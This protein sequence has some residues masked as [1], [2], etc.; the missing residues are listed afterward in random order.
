MGKAAWTLIV[1]AMLLAGCERDAPA[2]APDVSG[3]PTVISTEVSGPELSVLAIGDS[4]FAGYGLPDPMQSYPAQL[5]QALRRDGRDVRISNAGVS[6]DTSAAGRQRLAFT[7]D[8]QKSKP[9]LVLLEFGGNDLLRGLPPEQTRANLDAMLAELGK[10]GIPVAL[11]GMQAPPNE[12]P[13][14]QQAFDALF[15]GLAKA[16]GARLVPFVGKA[17]FTDAALLQAD[18]VHPTAQG[19]AKLVEATVP[20]IADALPKDD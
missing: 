20:L 2:P 6:G 13:Q 18:H 3:R 4:L 16:H 7:L 9:D 12:G 17:V 1:A 15:P 11:L 5:E 19:V 14:F 8:S 10:R